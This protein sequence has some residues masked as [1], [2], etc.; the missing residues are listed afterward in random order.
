VAGQGL[1]LVQDTYV[2]SEIAAGRLAL[3]PTRPEA[4][5]AWL[6]A[7]LERITKPHPACIG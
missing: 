3:H 1:A 4:L 2:E 5:L 6:P 7:F